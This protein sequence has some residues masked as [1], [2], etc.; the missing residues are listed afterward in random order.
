[1]IFFEKEKQMNTNKIA[2][3]IAN[4]VAREMIAK[5]AY[6][7]KTGEKL[8][9]YNWGDMYDSIKEYAAKNLV[10]KSDNKDDQKQI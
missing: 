4:I 2:N 6:E 5:S 7:R 10:I 3:K 8:P 1:M 9:E